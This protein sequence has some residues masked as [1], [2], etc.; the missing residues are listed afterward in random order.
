MDALL[1]INSSCLQEGPLPAESPFYAE[2]KARTRD[3]KMS[4]CCL[5]TLRLEAHAQVVEAILLAA[6]EVPLL[7]LP[8]E[9]VFGRSAASRSL[10]VSVL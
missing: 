10:V 3:E 1:L 4:I 2:L 5:H 9:V 7:S 8:K 6:R